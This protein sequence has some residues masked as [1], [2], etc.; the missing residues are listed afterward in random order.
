MSQIIIEK[1]KLQHNIDII[2]EKTKNIIDDKGNPLRVIAVLKG[3]AYG[4]GVEIVA[5][6]LLDNNINF[7]A[8]TE[9]EEALELRNKG[10]TNEILVLN[11]T[12]IKEEV[13][14]IVDNNLIAT[15]G[16]IE[17]IQ[18][19]DEIAKQK[20]K[21]ANCHLKIDTGFCRFGFN[22][23]ELINANKEIQS[24]DTN[25]SQTNLLCK[26]KQELEN[27]KNIKIVGTYSHFQESY[28]NDDKI[29][30]KQLNK[31]LDVIAK[32]KESKIETG[33]L[34][35]C[36]S[37]AFFKY[38]EM[39]LNAVRIGSAFSGRLQIS[40]TTGLQKVGFLESRICEIKELKKG[41]KVGYSGTCKLNK[42]SKIAIVEAGYSDGVGVTGPKDS[43]R[44][45]DKLRAL[46]KDLIALTKDGTRYV[47]IK[48]KKYPILGRIGMK[49][50]MIDISNSDIQIGEKVKIDIS[51]VLANQKVER[52]LR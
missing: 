14:K 25:N 33:I 19:L 32:L 9:V 28:S 16:S 17:V 51:L 1:A 42:D 7:F 34:H 3:N 37:S 39:Y 2:K 48:E 15:A 45:I 4:M 21:I 40:N 22:A 30:R 49:N 8:V 46:K 44:L 12:C 31:F 6:K 24:V 10:F 41:D 5:K 13:E 52:V 35:I 20:S 18:I 47:E 11:S 29:T 38:R 27:R 23:D 43:V 36:N 50:F 26:L